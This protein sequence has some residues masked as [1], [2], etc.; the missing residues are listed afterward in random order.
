M[1]NALSTTRELPR[2]AELPPD[3]PYGEAFR[4]LALNV[5]VILSERA[6]KGVVILSA[7]PGDGRSSVA[8]NLALA[9]AQET[10]VLLVDGLGGEEGKLRDVFQKAR[11]NSRPRPEAM[12]TQVTPTNYANVWLLNGAASTLASLGQLSEAVQTASQSGIITIVD[13]P[14]AATSSASFS[15]AREIGQAIYVVRNRKQD[16]GVHQGV[17]EQLRRLDVEILGLVLNER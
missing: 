1:L 2:L 12:P 3:S 4:L 10:S 13:T 8:A 16:M 5:S 17:R 15:L 7:Y 6:N 14:P 11:N 9:L